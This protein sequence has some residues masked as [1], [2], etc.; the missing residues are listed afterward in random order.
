[1]AAVYY[2]A[3]C[4]RFEFYELQKEKE[5]RN[6]RA[7]ANLCDQT[8]DRYLSKFCFFT[9][10]QYINSTIQYYHPKNH[11]DIK[12]GQG[13]RQG[14]TDTHSLPKAIGGINITI[15]KKK[16]RPVENCSTFFTHPVY[17]FEVFTPTC[18]VCMLR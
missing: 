9:H 15:V 4:D 8:S 11:K 10:V 1:M 14:S 12:F 2:V 13:G 7:S 5:S 6:T 17:I 18:H 3:V 16:Y